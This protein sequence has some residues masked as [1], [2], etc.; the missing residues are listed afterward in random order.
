MILVS[1]HLVNFTYIFFNISVLCLD[2]ISTMILVIYLLINLTCK[3]NM[4]IAYPSRF[5]TLIV[6]TYVLGKKIMWIYLIGVSSVILLFWVL[7]SPQW[8]LKQGNSNDRQ[9]TRKFSKLDNW[10]FLKKKNTHT[11]RSWVSIWFWAKGRQT[12][13]ANGKCT[14]PTQQTDHSYNDLKLQVW[15]G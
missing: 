3:D 7:I 4:S 13:L 11:H 14:P 1:T 9:K 15:L 6:I 12:E 5:I 10:N 8:M 2:C